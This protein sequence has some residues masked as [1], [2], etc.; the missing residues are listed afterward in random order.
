MTSAPFGQLPKVDTDYRGDRMTFDRAMGLTLVAGGL[1]WPRLFFLGLWIFGSQLGQAFSSWVIP[2]IGFFVAP[3]TTVAYA[4]MWGAGKDSVSGFWEWAVVGVAVLLDALT[5][6][7]V[8]RL[9]R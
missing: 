6:W 9:R 7:G 5:W 1:F 2:A 8:I 3:W 4:F